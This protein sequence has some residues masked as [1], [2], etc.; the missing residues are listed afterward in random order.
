MP[1]TQSSLQASRPVKNSALTIVR[2]ARAV[3]ELGLSDRQYLCE[4][5]LTHFG[6]LP[7]LRRPRTFNEK[8]LWRR[9]NDKR[10]LFETLCDKVAARAFVAEAAGEQY[11]VP[12]YG[13]YDRPEDIDWN[14]MPGPCVVKASHGSGWVEIVED[15]A[16]ADAARLTAACRRWLAADYSRQWREWQYHGVP[17][18]LLIERFL[19]K[20]GVPTIDYRFL[21][22]D[23]VPRV[24]YTAHDRF[25]NVAMTFYDLPWR[26]LRVRWQAPLGPREDPPPALA[27]MLELAANLS[28]GFDFVRV[29]LY[30]FEGRPYFSELTFTPNGGLRPF[31]PVEFDGWLGHLWTLPPV[32][33]SHS[34]GQ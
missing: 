4:R 10:P 22:F 27:E 7:D 6:R 2:R 29:D 15:P 30:C 8:I 13:V 23:G 17:R 18:R 14:S 16:H 12:C 3:V 21:C 11:L 20:G 26:R 1:R 28:C 32:A 24:I 19:G 25:A 31:D 33:L 34:I 9:L 5:Y